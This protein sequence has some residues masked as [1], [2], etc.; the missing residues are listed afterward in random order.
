LPHYIADTVS[1]AAVIIFMLLRIAII[2]AVIIAAIDIIINNTDFIAFAFLLPSFHDYA[3]TLL[4]SAIAIA[5][6]LFIITY[7]HTPLRY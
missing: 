1:P 4:H 3:A 6:T 2:I 5:D 7:T